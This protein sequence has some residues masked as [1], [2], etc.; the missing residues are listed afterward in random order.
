MID[1]LPGRACLTILSA[2]SVLCAA[3]ALSSAAAK[4]SAETASAQI[5]F[6]ENPA[7]LQ[8]P[9]VQPS[10]ITF[11]AD[12]NNTVT[13]LRWHAWG[14]SKARAT[15]TDHVDNCRPNCAQGHIVR[16]ATHL[17][18]YNRGRLR[19]RRMYLCY[20]VYFTVKAP[21]PAFHFCL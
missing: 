21:E 15:G 2:A 18:L 14:S 3:L 6:F 16:V 12:G 19:G 11:N 13:G 8:F 17:T 5:Y 7:V 20:H 9:R 1:R 4:G 10:Q